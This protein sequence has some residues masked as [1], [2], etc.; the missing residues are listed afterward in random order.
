MK[1]FINRPEDLAEE[2]M[3]GLAV[4][5]PSSTRLLGHK[6]MVRADPEQAHVQ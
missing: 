3:Q 2:M 6:V 1:K 4:L 5:H